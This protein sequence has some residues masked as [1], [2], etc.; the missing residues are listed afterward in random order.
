MELLVSLFNL[1]QTCPTEDH[2]KPTRL[3]LSK[4]A[5]LRCG[6]PLEMLRANGDTH[7]IIC[8]VGRTIHGTCFRAV[9]VVS[10]LVCKHWVVSTRSLPHN[11][12]CF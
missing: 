2:I 5:Y 12:K 4:A 8:A 10:W 7:M 1:N 11:L 6:I 3:S 9:S